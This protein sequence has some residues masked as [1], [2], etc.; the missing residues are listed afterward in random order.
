M[1]LSKGLIIIQSIR[2]AYNAYRHV[3]DILRF[4]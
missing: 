1:T 3:E 2:E 4:G